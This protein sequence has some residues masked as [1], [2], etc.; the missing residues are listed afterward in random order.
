MKKKDRSDSSHAILDAASRKRKAEKILRVLRPRTDLTKVKLLEI[1][2]GAG[3]MAEHI[4]RHVKEINSVDVVD[5]RRTKDGYSFN[6]VRDEQLP[7]EPASFDIV[8]SNHVIEHVQNQQLHLDEVLRVLKPGGILYLA[9]PNRY[10]ITDPHYR[11]PFINWLPRPLATQYLKTLQGKQWDIRPVTVG[12]I[13]N[14]T[15]RQHHIQPVVADIIK[16]P[17]TY[18]LDNFKALHPITRRLPTALLRAGSRF[19]PT[20]LLVVTKRH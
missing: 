12:N 14:W 13:R 10:W 9:T 2:T 20:I 15:K 5:E 1:G 3:Y 17:E 4:G 8:L 18:H 19:S 16:N 11:L 7:F 6:L